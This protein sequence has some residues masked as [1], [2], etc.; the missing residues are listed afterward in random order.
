MED[1]R[2]VAALRSQQCAQAGR[3]GAFGFWRHA[4]RQGAPGLVTHVVDVAIAAIEIAPACHL[5]QDGV[6]E[7]RW[8]AYR[9]C[10]LKVRL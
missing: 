10:R 2:E 1:D 5:E 8:L 3:D 6:D 9:L 4:L 7:H